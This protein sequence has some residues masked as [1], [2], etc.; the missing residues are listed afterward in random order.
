MAITKASETEGIE[1][2][3]E[4]KGFPPMTGAIKFEAKDGATIV[5]WESS[6]SVGDNYLFKMMNTFGLMESG[7]LEEY[8]KSLAKLK[9]RAEQRAADK[10]TPDE[11]S[12]QN[13]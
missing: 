1:Y 4:F 9:S 12:A 11:A 3:L 2:L 5:A 13:K 6:G 10:G 8:D 7:M